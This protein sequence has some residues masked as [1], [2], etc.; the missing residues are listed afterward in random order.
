M[1]E[2]ESVGTDAGV[3]EI[4]KWLIYWIFLAFFVSEDNLHLKKNKSF[5]GKKIWVILISSPLFSFY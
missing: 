4:L 5:F 2:K 1:Q 3:F